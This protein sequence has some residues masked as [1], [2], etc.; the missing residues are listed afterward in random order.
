MGTKIC[1]ICHQEKPLNEFA[2]RDKA[3]GLRSNQC[4]QCIADQQRIK[5]HKQKDELNAYKATQKCVKCGENR[6][7]VLDFHHIDPNTKIN[8]IAKLST[9]SN[10]E[11]VKNEIQKCVCLCA[12]CHREFHYL[13]ELT[14][15]SFEEYCNS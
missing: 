11:A 7:Y 8:T 12:N 3:K 9:H 6:F 4:K 2:F 13:N 5:Y 10:P 14:G 15:I 1:T